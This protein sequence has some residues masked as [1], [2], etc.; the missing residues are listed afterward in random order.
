M[1]ES[2]EEHGHDKDSVGATEAVAELRTEFLFFFSLVRGA[3]ESKHDEA[4][5]GWL[6]QV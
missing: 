5:L 1:E 3:Y 4:K 6:A 2:G